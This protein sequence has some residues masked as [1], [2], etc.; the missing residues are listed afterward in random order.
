VT[1]IAEEHFQLVPASLISDDD[2]N[3]YR[4]RFTR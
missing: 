4:S 1:K 2:L 3:H